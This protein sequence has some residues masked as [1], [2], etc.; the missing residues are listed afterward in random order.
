[1]HFSGP[2]ERMREQRGRS[3]DYKFLW[4]KSSVDTMPFSNKK[5]VPDEPVIFALCFTK[6]P[7]SSSDACLGNKTFDAETSPG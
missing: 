4:K 7:H 6:T 1:R 2:G 3:S 5:N